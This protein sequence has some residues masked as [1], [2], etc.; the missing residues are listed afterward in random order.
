MESL[1]HLAVV[2]N[3]AKD[4]RRLAAYCAAAK[5]R[6]GPHGVVSV[7]P[8]TGPADV[9]TQARRA[10]ADGHGLIVAAGGDGTLLGV[11]HA[12]RGTEVAVTVLPL[13]TSN[14]YAKALGIRSERDALRALRA[15]VVRRADLIACAYTGRDGTPH[16]QVIC[17]SAGLGFTAAVART[18]RSPLMSLLKRGVGNAAFFLASAKLVATYHGSRADLMLDGR[19]HATSFSLLEVSKVARIG[20]MG[21][22]PRARPDS[23]FLDAC[24]FDGNVARRARLLLGMQVSDRHVG[25]RD[26]QYF[27]DDPTAN[28]LGVCSL[29]ELVVEPTR[30]TPLHLHGDFVGYGPARFTIMPLALRV[31]A[32]DPAPG[33]GG[34]SA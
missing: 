19:R 7:Y 34:P 14:D 21:L 10:V 16:E 9:E 27:S 4:R 3:G 30:R 25:W 5:P 23:G 20:G 13:G 2:F 29:R 8:S 33:R 18:E 15:G 22:T 6:L 24:L 31:L 12:V 26:Y 32:L 11:L 1:S 17:L 28:A